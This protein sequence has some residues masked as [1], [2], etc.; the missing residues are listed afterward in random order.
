MRASC[1]ISAE[2]SQIIRAG[3]AWSNQ[4][5]ITAMAWRMPGQPSGA[6]CSVSGVGTMSIV[7]ASSPVGSKSEGMVTIS[8]C[9]GKGGKISSRAQKMVTGRSGGRAFRI[10]AQRSA[11]PRP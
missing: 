8:T 3:S 6:Q 9:G 7:P 2:T 1:A 5:A 11:W 4:L 10:A